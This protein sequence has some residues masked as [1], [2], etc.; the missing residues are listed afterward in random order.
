MNGKR[1]NQD[2]HTVSTPIFFN[3]LN[4]CSFLTCKIHRMNAFSHA[5]NLMLF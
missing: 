2:V 4:S 3:I 1:S 5:Y